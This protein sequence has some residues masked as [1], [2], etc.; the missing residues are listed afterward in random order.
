MFNQDA[1]QNLQLCFSN[2]YCK[3]GMEVLLSFWC[4]LVCYHLIEKVKVAY[5]GWTFWGLIMRKL[6][7]EG[8]S[9]T[10]HPHTQIWFISVYKQFIH[11]SLY[12]N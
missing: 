5:I 1:G 7:G 11:I 2:A 8:A 4:Y 6:Q 9:D 3:I 12:K 10:P